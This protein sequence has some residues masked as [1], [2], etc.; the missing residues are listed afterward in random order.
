DRTLRLQ[1]PGVPGELLIGGAG[2][3]RGYHGRPDLTAERFVPDPFAGP[4][5]AGARLYR[6]GDLVRTLAAGRMDFLGRIDHQ[7]KLRGHRIELGEIETLLGRHPGVD[8]GVVV[9]RDERLV[10]YL[11][12][13]GP[14]PAVE[15][16]RGF[17]R[18]QLPEYM[19]P[20][21]FVTLESLPL[22]PNR[23]VDRRALPSPEGARPELET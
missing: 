12:P 16:L 23:K 11:V 22:T 5:E 14:K 2:L 18:E 15:E 17:L 3:A 21:L 13:A 10:A 6:T 20:S 4:S 19:V 8:E 7:I 1:P 9:V